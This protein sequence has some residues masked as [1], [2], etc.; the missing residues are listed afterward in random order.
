M[1]RYSNPRLV[2]EGKEYFDGLSF[3]PTLLGEGQQEKHD[4]LYWEFH[5]TNM[6]A[7]RMGNWKLVVQNGKCQLYDLATDLHEDNDLAAQY[8]E[9]VAEMKAV[10]LREHTESD[11]FKVTLPQ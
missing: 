2:K 3:A 4:F 11:K 9:V 1:E 7:L 10:L 5:E 8:P 6:M